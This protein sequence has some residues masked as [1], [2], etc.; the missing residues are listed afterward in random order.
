MIFCSKKGFTLIELMVVI[1]IIGILAAALITPITNAQAAARALHC[2]TN[3]KNLAQAALSYAGDKHSGGGGIHLRDECM[4][5]AGTFEVSWD[6]GEDLDYEPVY[7]CCPGW[8]AGIWTGVCPWNGRNLAPVLDAS[9][10]KRAKFYSSAYQEVCNSLTNGLLWKYVGADMSTYSCDAHKKV[11]KRKGGCKNVLRSYVMNAFFG[12]NYFANS[13]DRIATGATR[14]ISG[15]S[16]RGSAATLL[17]FA[18]LPAY[19][20]DGN[21]SVDTSKAAADGVL[22]ARI[23]GYNNSSTIREE[24]IGFNHRIA[25]GMIANVAFADGHVD[26]VIAPDGVT[27]IN[28]KDLTFLLCNGLAVPPKV[29]EWATARNAFN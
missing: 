29:S 5:W 10:D 6:G 15:L 23:V 25:R 21:E 7:H 28:L 3:L 17:L 14:S 22:E 12:Y 8:V 11:A 18:E 1:A 2:K 4:P 26:A 27:E 16:D 9:D 13:N 19:D 24:R 20:K